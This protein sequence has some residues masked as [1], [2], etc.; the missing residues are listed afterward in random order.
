MAGQGIRR[1]Q[2][3]RQEIRSEPLWEIRGVKLSVAILQ[4]HFFVR[5]AGENHVLRI[6]R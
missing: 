5:M 1:L 3:C 2:T 4:E 6:I